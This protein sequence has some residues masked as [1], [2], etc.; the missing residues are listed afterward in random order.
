MLGKKKSDMEDRIIVY[1]SFYVKNPE[2]MN[3]KQDADWWL[4][5][6]ERGKNEE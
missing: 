3:H 5:G 1:D 4:P 2:Q 6:A